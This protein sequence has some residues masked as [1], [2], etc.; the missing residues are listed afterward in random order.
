MFF[1]SVDSKEF[2]ITV[3]PLEATLPRWLGS[4]E[5]KGLRRRYFG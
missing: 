2:N 3:S 4:V 5:N 1:V